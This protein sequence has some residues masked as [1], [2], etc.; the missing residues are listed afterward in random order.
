M[1][2]I[3]RLQT[4]EQRSEGKQK[5]STLLCFCWTGNKSFYTWFYGN[6]LSLG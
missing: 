6:C 4:G 3:R 2:L 1:G 5:K